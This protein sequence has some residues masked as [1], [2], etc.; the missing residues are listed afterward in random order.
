MR[1]FITSLCLLTMAA[2]GPAFA[3]YA[4]VDPI[5]S[6]QTATSVMANKLAGDIASGNSS[7]NSVS[8]RCFAN[9]G[10][11]RRA[12]EAEHARRW[13]SDGK[14]SADAWGKAR[15]GSLTPTAVRG[16]SRGRTGGSCKLLPFST[17]MPLTISGPV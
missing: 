13:K 4:P 15:D 8:T 11:E 3:Q 17:L 12:M 14:A 16:P 9:S 2:P 7:S 6:G 10:P 1:V 5:P